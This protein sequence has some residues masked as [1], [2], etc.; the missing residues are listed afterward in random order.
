[1][2]RVIAL[3][4]HGE[5]LDRYMESREENWIIA[6]TRPQDPVLSP[7]AHEQVT[8]VAQHLQQS[9][10]SEGI[11]NSDIVIISSP[12]IRTVQTA[13]I[14]SQ[15]LDVKGKICLEPAIIEEYSWMRGYDV[16]EPKTCFPI[17]LS[18]QELYDT[19]S[20][21][22][23]LSYDPYF[24]PTFIPDSNQRNGVR[25]CNP[26]LPD[27]QQSKVLVRYRCRDF[28]QNFVMNP[29]SK[30]S[31]YRAVVVIGHGATNT[32]C[33]I[34]LQEHLPAEDKFNICTIANTGAWSVFLERENW[35]SIHPGW[36]N[37]YVP[38]T[39]DNANDRPH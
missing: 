32:G 26:A 37:S 27:E 36:N 8:A 35:K 39:V 23:D 34:G 38:G 16:G 1:M 2:S 17:F 21:N 31:K 28:I 20:Q 24:T 3:M 10:A 6:A 30:I 25:E 5:R 11:E 14:V 4:R 13:E 29:S 7:N 33:V 19:Y 12:L 9:L 18:P 22:I 15:V